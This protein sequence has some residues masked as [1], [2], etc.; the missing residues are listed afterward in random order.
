ICEINSG[1]LA[2]PTSL[3]KGWLDQVRPNNQQGEYYLTD[4]IAMAVA[5]G[6]A[7]DGIF[8]T[9]PVEVIGVNDRV[10]LAELERAYQQQQVHALMLAG[11]SFADPQR[12]DIRGTLTVGRDCFIDINTVF[13]GEVILADN[14]HIGPN[15]I[16]SD[17]VLG[18]GVYVK[19]NTLVEG[20]VVE[21]ACELGPFARIRPGTEL[22]AGVKIGNFVEVKK[23]K[24]ARGVKA[25]HLAYLGDAT[26]GAE[27]NI[28]AGTVTCNYDGTNKHPTIIGENVFVGTNST[29]VAPLNIGDEAFVAAGSTITKTVENSHLA[30][31]RGKQRN[32]S[33]WTSPVKRDK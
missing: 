15:S 7:V 12:V 8:A 5:D 1:I 10:Q 27:C 20:A 18:D 2:A 19:P 32:I 31:G 6:V 13:E 22:G 28:G 17:S 33:G 3:L 30:V 14:V 29:L 9:S 11:V 21:K 16:I 23:S 26:I 25:G 24:L 4:I